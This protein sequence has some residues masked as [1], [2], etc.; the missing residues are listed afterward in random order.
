MRSLAT[1]V[2][3][4]LGVEA[5][6]ALTLHPPAQGLVH[7]LCRVGVAGRG[8]TVPPAVTAPGPATRGPSQP[9][10]QVPQGRAGPAACSDT[11]APGSP[12]TNE[13][14]AGW[15]PVTASR[16]HGGKGAG[17]QL[18]LRPPEPVTSGDRR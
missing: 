3:K 12:P 18:S 1:E 16:A 9:G 8:P 4:V 6:P 17:L 15:P 14:S 10:G 13:G 5:P 11:A 2:T 7:T